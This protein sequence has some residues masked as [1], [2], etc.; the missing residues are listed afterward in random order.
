MKQDSFVTKVLRRLI[1]W[2]LEAITGFLWWGVGIIPSHTIRKFF[3]R[4]SGMK[5]AH[6]ST[7]HMMARIYDPR[8]IIIGEDTIVGERAT[9]DGRK[10]LPNSGGGLQI[11]DHTDI[12]SEVMIWT[13]QHDIH[14][15]N[16]KAIEKKVTIGDYV[17]IGPRSIILPGVNI[18]NGA[19]IAAGAVVTKNVE[20]FAIVAG[21]PAQKIG[22][23]KS[24]LSSTSKNFNYKL[25]RT[26]L[27]Q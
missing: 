18:G 22:E 26:R 3:Y 20:P 11:G 7:I 21:T 8:H 17:F 4:L 14:D 27:F 5:I 24:T 16:F 12:A 25:G 15:P 9:L 19:I 23:R 6:G 10:Q 13:S 2:H 1:A